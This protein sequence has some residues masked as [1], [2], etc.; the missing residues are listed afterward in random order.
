MREKLAQMSELI[1]ENLGTTQSTQK[2]WYDQTA[3]SRE[4]QMANQVLPSSTNK[5]LA[6]WQGP[7]TVLHWIGK[8]TYQ[9]N[10]HDPRRRRTFHI[11]MLKRTYQ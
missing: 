1:A 8:V 3:R 2:Y 5:M 7:Y 9:V 6:Q 4:F 11:N 10:M